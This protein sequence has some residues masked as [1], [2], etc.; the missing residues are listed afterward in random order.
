MTELYTRRGAA[1]YLGISAATLDR[2]CAARGI[3]FVQRCAGGKKFF[4]RQ[5][6]DAYLERFTR[7]ARV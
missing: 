6:L 5:A 3:A 2:I 1:E 4:T 7:R